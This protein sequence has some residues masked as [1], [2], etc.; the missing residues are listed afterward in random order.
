MTLHTE[1]SAISDQIQA[2]IES[3]TFLFSTIRD[4]KTESKTTYG[5]VLIPSSKEIFGDIKNF[6]ATYGQSLPYKASQCLDTFLNEFQ[7]HVLVQNP[8]ALSTVQMA[9]TLLASLRSRLTYHLS[10]IQAQARR[11]TERA[12][13]HLQRSIVVDLDTRARWKIAFESHETKCEKLGAVHLLS[14]GIWA[15]KAHAEGGHTDLILGEPIR[16]LNQVE[17]TA[18]ALVLTEWKVV[19]NLSEL[20]KKAQEAYEQAARYAGETLAG[21]ELAGYR[22]LVL[23]SDNFMD[24]PDHRIEREVTYQHI[25][26]AVSP[27]LPSNR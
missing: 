14:H 10:D 13:V 19:R 25:N 21:I 23:V 2:L 11:I 1:W 3:G 8:T 15:F 18:D 4:T 12:F 5:Q 9:L 6:R 7:K 20:E 22:Y 24:M 16:D 17:A 26:I 27:Q